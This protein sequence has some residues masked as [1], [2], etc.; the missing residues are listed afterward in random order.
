VT[1]LNGR[2]VVLESGLGLESGLESVLRGLGL[3]LG[4][5]LEGLGLGLGLESCGLGLGLGLG[6]CW[7]RYKSGNTSTPDECTIEELLAKYLR[8]EHGDSSDSD[9]FGFWMQRETESK[10]GKL[11]PAVLR[12]FAIPAS[13][14]PVE[15]V[16]SHGGI[17][18]RPNRAR[19]SDKLLSELVFLKCNAL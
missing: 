8:T 18:L 19:M 11:L 4:L 5:E 16:F 12:A 1:P 17:M 14:A 13:S 15:R 3:G 10:Y 6:H 7:T 2:L 9:A